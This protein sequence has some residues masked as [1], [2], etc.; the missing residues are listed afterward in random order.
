MEAM[1]HETRPVVE[2]AV[3]G[4]D[5]FGEPQN[6]IHVI[7]IDHAVTLLGQLARA[8]YDARKL[9]TPACVYLHKTTCPAA[10]D[11]PIGLWICN[12]GEKVTA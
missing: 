2:I 7:E 4:R 5:E 9:Q 8:I 1:A 11:M 3:P 6:V 12:C 10:R